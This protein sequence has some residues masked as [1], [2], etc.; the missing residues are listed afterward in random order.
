MEEAIGAYLPLNESEYGHFLKEFSN[1][2]ECFPEGLV[3]FADTGCGD[4]ICFD[5]RQGTDNPNPSIVYWFHEAEPG[6]DVSF[7]ANNFEEFLGML[8]QPEDED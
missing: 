6:K 4:L 1:P 7:I 2:P 5:Y 8:T 3:V